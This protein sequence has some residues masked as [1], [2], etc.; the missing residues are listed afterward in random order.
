MTPQMPGAHK[1]KLHGW[2]DRPSRCVSIAPAKSSKGHAK[3]LGKHHG[4]GQ[5]THRLAAHHPH[6]SGGVA[7]FAPS[8]IA[9]HASTPTPA[10]AS[11]APAPAA[12]SVWNSGFNFDPFTAAQLERF[13]SLVANIDQPPKYL[14]PIYKAAGRRYHIQWQILAAINSIETNY[15]ADL[16][17]SPA[18]AIGWM[19]FMPETWLE[20]RVAV[21]SSSAPNPYDPQDAIFSA[22]RYLAANGASRHIRRALYA[23]NHALWYVDAVLW[24]A[25]LIS[26]RALGRRARRNGYA[27]PLDT[28]YMRILG[29]IDDGVDIEDAP[30]GAAVYSITP[31]I[32]TAVASDPSG[33]GPNYPVILVTR[34]PLAGQYI[35]YGH[36]AA[37]L[38]HVGQRVL[39]GQPVAVM[40]HTGDAAGLGHGHIEIGFSD[41]SGDPLNHHGPS[42]WTPSGDA[43]HR[44]LRALWKAFLAGP[45]HSTSIPRA[46]NPQPVEPWTLTFRLEHV[47]GSSR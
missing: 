9:P 14:I 37:S 11:T 20:Y 31:G 17:V 30:D 24:R 25:A 46:Q 8:T 4:V 45:P 19:Q 33:F 28:R 41:G 6:S 2:A 3:H 40:G 15:G 27:L 7:P 22:A 12:P 38:V 18:G 47:R 39:A 32:V 1:H 10:A 35:Y 16:A 29:R 26:D 44:V 5:T 21:D 36:V 43:M 42:A 13:S 23:Y 34:G